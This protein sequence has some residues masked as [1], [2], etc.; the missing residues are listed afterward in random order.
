MADHVCIK[1]SAINDIKKE[2]D[3]I[4]SRQYTDHDLLIRIE[5]VIETT[6]SRFSEEIKNLTLK[7][8]E[9]REQPTNRFEKL[10][11]ASYVAI[12]TAVIS[13]LVQYVIGGLQ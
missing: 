2:I 6:F 1:E 12:A 7:V 4:N 9:L 5:T 11:L 8:D 13:Y 3:N 10:R